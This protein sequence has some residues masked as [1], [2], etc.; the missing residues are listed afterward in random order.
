MPKSS[1]FNAMEKILDNAGIPQ[2]PIHALRDTHAVLQLEAGATLE[3]AQKRLG[4]KNYQVTVDKYSHISKKIEKDT[5]NK[6][7]NRMNEIFDK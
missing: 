1:L 3:Y 6:Y 4:H 5:L 7:D 2:I